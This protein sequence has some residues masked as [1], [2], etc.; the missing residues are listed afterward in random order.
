MLWKEEQSPR[1]ESVFSG[2][3]MDNVRKE[4]HV[5]SVMTQRPLETAALVRDEMDDR[6]LAH[7]I[8]R[9]RLTARDK[10]PQR[11]QATKRNTLQTKKEL[12]SMPVQNL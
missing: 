1:V 3:H 2:G 5:V 4:T 6:L 9:Q 10:Y 12:N 7:P 11:N 8:R